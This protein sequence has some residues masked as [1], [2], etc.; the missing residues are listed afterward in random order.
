[1]LL[2]FCPEFKSLAATRHSGT[3]LTREHLLFFFPVFLCLLFSLISSP[4]CGLAYFLQCGKKKTAHVLRQRAGEEGESWCLDVTGGRKK[5]RKNTKSNTVSDIYY[6]RPKDRRTHICLR[7]DNLAASVLVAPRSF[8]PKE[9]YP[10]FS[11][12][13]FSLWKKKSYT[14]RDRGVSTTNLAAHFK[15]ASG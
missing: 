10:Y 14:K 5:S 8:A 3:Q 12:S 11:S 15:L 9:G 13:F 2:L 7:A 1:M 6:K 4:H